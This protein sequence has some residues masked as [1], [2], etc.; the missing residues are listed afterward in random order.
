MYKADDL[1]EETEEIILTRARNDVERALHSAEL[2]RNRHERSTG[3]ELPRAADQQKVTLQQA[4]LNWEKSRITLPSNQVRQKLEL[5][6]TQLERKKAEDKLAELKRD[7]ELMTIAAPVSGIV[8]YG[9]SQNGKWVTAG[10]VGQKLRPGGQI[11][12]HETLFTIVADGTWVVRAT[13]AEK[14]LAAVQPG[15]AGRAKLTA[16]PKVRLPVKVRDVANAPNSDGSFDSS[17]DL[18]APSDKLIA[19]MSCEVKLTT[20]FNPDAVTVPTAAVFR[21]ELDEEKE[22]VYVQGADG[23]PEKRPVV[24]GHTK[25]DMTE[26]VSGLSASDKIFP[27]KPAL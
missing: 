22:F 24:T 15:A 10:A 19:G 8:H 27:Q 14:D 20:Y 6:R 3:V 1:T 26:I 11:M 9:R 18:L 2:A 7:R 5:E 4:L 25:G 13:V 16:F 17:L 23:K 21:E 12:P